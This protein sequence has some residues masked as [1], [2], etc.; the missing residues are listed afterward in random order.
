MSTAPEAP[1]SAA[2]APGLPLA[3]R[4][5]LVTGAGS[6]M[7]RAHCELMAARGA[8]VI[9]QDLLPERAEAVAAAIRDSGGK[10]EAMAGDA[11]DVLHMRRSIAA[12]LDRHGHIGIIVNN[13]GIPSLVKP[14]EDIEEALFDDMLKVNIKSAFFCTQALVPAMKA[15][16]W[17]RIINVSSFFAMVGS[18]NGAHYT[19]A[20]GGMLGLTKALARELAPWQI[21]VNAIAPGL[22]KTEMTTRSL[23]TDEAFAARARTVPMGRLAEP[24]EVA[25]T[26]AFLASDD[27]AMLTGA[28][29][30]P[31]GGEGLVGV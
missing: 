23:K 29:L 24:H 25:A 13:A 17:G 11:S 31:S 15:A 6:G 10:A 19:T 21:T 18:P 8:H 16:R 27:A 9:V 4:V 26:V 5:A 2:R 20:K 28:T 12:A 3:G 22:V 30:S 1:S 7:G 14:F